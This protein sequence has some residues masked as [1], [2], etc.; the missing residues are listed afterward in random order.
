[1]KTNPSSK[2]D[3][4]TPLEAMHTESICLGLLW[5][6]GAIATVA[7]LVFFGINE[8]KEVFQPIVDA[9]QV[10]PTIK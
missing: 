7:L 5:T 4:F 3:H 1:M 10:Q 8:V 6:L 2:K 9:L